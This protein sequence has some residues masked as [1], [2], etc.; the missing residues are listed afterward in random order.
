MVQ[1]A[2][3]L[4]PPTWTAAAEAAF[5]P[6]RPE[7]Q[8]LEQQAEHTASQLHDKLAPLPPL[9]VALQDAVT[10]LENQAREAAEDL[11]TAVM[12]AVPSNSGINSL[13]LPQNPSSALNAASGQVQQAV[14][15]LDS[16]LVSGLSAL[17]Q[18]IASTSGNSV[19]QQLG[20]QAAGLERA[21]SRAAVQLESA[22]ASGLQHVESGDAS[23][24]LELAGRAGRATLDV[25]RAAAAPFDLFAGNYVLNSLFF[26]V[27]ILLTS[28]L[29][30][31]APR[32]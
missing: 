21:A 29:L 9:H 22:L 24:V 5:G 31:T 26:A 13:R 7:L 1:V 16:A 12:Q 2:A 32:Q 11:M 19:T 23:V 25:A 18:Q 4:V 17:Q 3:G 15:S 8:T 6:A 20:T 30:V 10:Q 28:A 27:V 14:G